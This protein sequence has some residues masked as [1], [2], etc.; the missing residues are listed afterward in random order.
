[1]HIP[2]PHNNEHALEEKVGGVLYGFSKLS[3]L[4]HLVANAGSQKDRLEERKSLG[5]GLSRE[6]K[7]KKGGGRSDLWDW[8]GKKAKTA[9]R[10]VGLYCVETRSHWKRRLWNNEKRTQC[11]DSEFGSDR[12]VEKG[13]DWDNIWDWNT[14]RKQIDKIHHVERSLKMIDK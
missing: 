4:Q 6:G 3:Y 2:F 8:P 5:Q 12:W 13:K 10:D 7:W 11:D 1:M 9:E 14:E